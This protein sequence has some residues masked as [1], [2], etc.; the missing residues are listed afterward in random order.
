MIKTNLEGAVVTIRMVVTLCLFLRRSRL[1]DVVYVVVKNVE[2]EIADLTSSFA[3]AF[4]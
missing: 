3:A 1:I 2:A 4:T